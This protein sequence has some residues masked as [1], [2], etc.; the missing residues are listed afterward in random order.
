[1]KLR[2]LSQVLLAA[3]TFASASA[4]AD[5]VSYNSTLSSALTDQDQSLSFQQ[6][7]SSLGTL[8]SVT[9]SFDTTISTTV[10]SIASPD[11]TVYI[12]LLAELF[13]THPDAVTPL[14]YDSVTLFDNQS[15]T[16]GAGGTASTSGSATISASGLTISASDFAL[17]TH[18]GAGTGY[19]FA[20]LYVQTSSSWEGDDGQ[21]K[22]MTYAAGTAK[23]TYN[24]T[25]APVP[26]PETYGMMLLGLGV[27]GLMAKRKSRSARV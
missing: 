27:V 20:P 22:F 12:S 26:E 14:Y 4:M 7:N 6:F 11:S 23:V 16:A 8:N 3:A 18:A 15:L 5:V 17:F 10:S 21:V 25:A 9:L 2:K 19:V 1:M 24:F 13:L